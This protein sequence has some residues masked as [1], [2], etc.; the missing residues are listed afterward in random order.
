MVVVLKQM[1][2]VL[3][4]LLIKVALVELH[5]VDLQ[6]TQAVAVVVLA[7][8]VGMEQQTTVVRVE[9]ELLQAS[10]EHL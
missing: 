2:L 7:P 4:V 8:L 10:Q 1:L 9:Q 3:L 6:V 5:L